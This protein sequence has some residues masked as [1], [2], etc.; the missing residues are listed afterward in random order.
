[1]S[2][3]FSYPDSVCEA[4]IDISSCVSQFSRGSIESVGST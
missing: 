4:T 3:V 2:S 1:M